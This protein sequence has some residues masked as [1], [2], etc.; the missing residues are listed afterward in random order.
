MDV[1]WF[2]KCQANA[3]IDESTNPATYLGWEPD[4]YINWEV[5]SDLTLTFRYGLFDPNLKAFG[6]DKGASSCILGQSLRSERTIA[7]FPVVPGRV[8]RG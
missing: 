6:N 5:L 3:P 7:E 1:Y 2:N 8:W 4:F